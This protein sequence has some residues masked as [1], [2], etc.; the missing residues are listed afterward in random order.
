[1]IIKFNKL[2]VLFICILVTSPICNAGLL[3]FLTPAKII[4]QVKS[5]V[6]K[7]KIQQEIQILDTSII[8]GIGQGIKFKYDSEPSYVDQYYT[9]IDQYS[10]LTDVNI[11]TLAGADLTPFHF[12]ISKGSDITFA[13]QFNSQLDSLVALP[14]TPANIPFTA[15]QMKNLKVGDFVGFTTTL[16]L[17]TS[18]NTVLP[19]GAVNLSLGAYALLQGQFM[20][21]LFKMSESNF[22]VK[23][24]ALNTQRRGI[25]AVLDIFGATILNKAKQISVLGGKIASVVDISPLVFGASKDRT[26]L[27]MFDYIFNSKDKRAIEAYNNFSIRKVMFKDISLVNPFNGFDKVDENILSDLTE[28]DSIASEDLNK[29]NGEKGVE[30]IFSGEN[31]SETK[32]NNLNFKFSVV[33]VNKGSTFTQNKIKTTDKFNNTDHFLFDS[34]STQTKWG[35]F[36]DFFG[37]EN[38]MY[39]NL[40]FKAD[41]AFQPVEFAELVF[42]REIKIKQLTEKNYK[43]LKD[44][45]YQVLPENIYNKIEWKKI[46][47]SKETIVNGFFKNQVSF[48]HDA[49]FAIPSLSQQEVYY[50]L[51][52]ILKDIPR[53]STPPQVENNNTKGFVY[54]SSN[55]TD[56]YEQEIQLIATAISIFL[57]NNRSTLERYNEF[58]KLRDTE[59]WRAIAPKFFLTV[60]PEESLEKSVRYELIFEAK[61]VDS[62][63]F[64]HGVVSEGELYKNLLYIQSILSNRS[65]DLRFYTNDNGSFQN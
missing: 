59:I 13:R 33:N 63:R 41:E 36:F 51:V 61:G 5:S 9:R 3:S 27:V 42:S 57:D 23:I 29:P 48:T 20:I 7:A 43:N 50:I 65:F 10:I 37:F 40:L 58:L 30:R 28:V 53:P 32:G 44:H 34:Y 54:R 47:F 26:N 4:Q 60:I 24:I 14:Y 11:G 16:N 22:R 64:K 39:S 52:N 55:W 19:S 46:D 6:A 25:D 12:S 17:I 21:H 1:M 62:L 45:V 38:N 18:I 49:L 2:I 56:D 31:K 15:D 8:D 35:W